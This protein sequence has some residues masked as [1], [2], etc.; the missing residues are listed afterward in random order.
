MKKIFVFLTSILLLV[1]CDCCYCPVCGEWDCTCNRNYVHYSGS[2]YFCADKLLGT[3]QCDYY[4]VVGNM[5]IKE[6]KFLDNHTCDITYA[7]GRYTDWYT[8][9]YLYSYSSGY[10]RFSRDGINFMFQVSG[11]LFPELYVRDSF[12][13]YTWKKV[14]AYGC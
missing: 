12:G 1:S 14:R 9:T 4:T 13:N 3:W 8:D 7:N 11:Y 5:T 10:L 6:I 2:D